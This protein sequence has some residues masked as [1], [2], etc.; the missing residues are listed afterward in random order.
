MVNVFCRYIPNRYFIPAYRARWTGRVGEGGDR[1]RDRQWTGMVR[2]KG[3]MA[4]TRGEQG[5]GG[6]AR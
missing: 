6:D 3:E 2:G 5:R 4:M 1:G